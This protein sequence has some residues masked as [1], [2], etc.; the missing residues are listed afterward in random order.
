M[1]SAWGDSWGDAWGDSWKARTPTV[2]PEGDGI[3]VSGNFGDGI[4][5][6]SSF[7]DGIIVGGDL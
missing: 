7:G 6:T 3:V 2:I 5:A 4:A 1:D